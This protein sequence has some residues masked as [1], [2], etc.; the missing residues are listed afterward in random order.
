MAISFM[1]THYVHVLDGRVRVKVP[2]IRRRETAAQ[3]L[4]NDLSCLDGVLTVQ[5]NSMTGNVLVR[6]DHKIVDAT[7]I[8]AAIGHLSGYQIPLP[9]PEETPK[10]DLEIHPIVINLGREIG[11]QILKNTLPGWAVT[12][13][14]MASI[15]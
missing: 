13:A 2:A 6:F 12:L 8:I 15:L 5:A 9:A 1:D 7:E 3:A 10:S 4:K 11:K 14:E